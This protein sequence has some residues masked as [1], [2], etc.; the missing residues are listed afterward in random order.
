MGF[1][2]HE[3]ALLV[4][5]VVSALLALDSTAGARMHLRLSFLAAF[6]VLPLLP[7]P[8]LKLLKVRRGSVMRVLGCNRLY[9]QLGVW[10]WSGP[11]C[12]G[13]LFFRCVLPPT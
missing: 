2:V 5:A 11:P 7:G 4:P 9:V 12:E 1:H 10:P 6:A 8:E 3:K 13:R